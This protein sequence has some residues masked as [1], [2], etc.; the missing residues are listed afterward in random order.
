MNVVPIP[1]PATARSPGRKR[2][3]ESE[4]AGKDV[5]VQEKNNS[6]T[7]STS[8]CTSTSSTSSINSTISTSSKLSY[9][10]SLVYFSGVPARFLQATAGQDG[11]PTIIGVDEAGRGC[12]L[13]AMVYGAAFWLEAE[14]VEMSAK[15]Y[16]DSKGLTAEVRE[17]LYTAIKNDES[18]NMG[19]VTVSIPA[20]AI[21]C[22][23][24]RQHP[25]SLNKMSWDCCVN[26]V[27]RIISEGVNVA[28]VY[29]D[30][31]GDPEIY[32]SW[33]TRQFQGTVNFCVRKKADSLFKVVSAAS[34]CAKQTRDHE[35][36]AYSPT[37]EDK[38]WLKEG[39]SVI[40]HSVG[41]GYPSDPRTKQF[42]VDTHDPIF[43]FSSWVRHSWAPCKLINKDSGVAFD[44]GEEEEDGVL[45]GQATMGS[46]FQKKGAAPADK[47]G[48]FYTARGIKRARMEDL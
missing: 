18:E 40:G 46:F 35:L 39:Q 9:E 41:S 29:V 23:M 47:R 16:D 34:I 45:E 12:V 4:T 31:V 21:S 6:S 22:K 24:F 37:N 19:F 10:D 48:I 7:S 26:M 14:D 36:E 11:P 33:L 28:K 13:G 44:F 30:T 5:V 42:L 25:Y 3:F 8:S 15:G 27:R 38:C 17:K 1:L 43:G 32:E 20:T 2:K